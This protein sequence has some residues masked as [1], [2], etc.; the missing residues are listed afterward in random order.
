MPGTGCRLADRPGPSGTA[1]KWGATDTGV[2]VFKAPAFMYGKNWT[3]DHDP[4]SNVYAWPPRSGRTDG[5][6]TTMPPIPLMSTA[7]PS[8]SS[9]LTKSG[10]DEGGF[11]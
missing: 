11:V 6:A 9:P 8:V 7:R 10:V 2:S 4:S 1:S 5:G 3:L